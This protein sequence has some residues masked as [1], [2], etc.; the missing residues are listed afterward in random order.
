MADMP[1]DQL[2][3]VRSIEQE[4]DWPD[5]ISIVAKWGKKTS[6]F[7]ITKDHF[8]GYGIHGAPLNGDQL[9]HQINTLRRQKP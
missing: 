8:Y 6:E 1:K 5:S 2:S 9:L 4:Q 3:R 7:V